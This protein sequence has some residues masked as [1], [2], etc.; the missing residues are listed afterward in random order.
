MCDECWKNHNS[1][2]LPYVN[3]EVPHDVYV[4]KQARNGHGKINYTVRLMARPS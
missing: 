2:H 1:A 3:T 4:I